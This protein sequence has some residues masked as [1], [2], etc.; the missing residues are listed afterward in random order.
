MRALFPASKDGYNHGSRNRRWTQSA[1]S[2]YEKIGSPIR[3]TK[4]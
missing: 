3:S 1:E 2:S 4:S